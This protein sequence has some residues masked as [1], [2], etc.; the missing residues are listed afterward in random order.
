[1]PKA[2]H[3]PVDLIGCLFVLQA[4]PGT[5]LPG[6]GPGLPWLHPRRCTQVWR[7][8]SARYSS[9]CSSNTR[10]HQLHALP[11]YAVT[12]DLHN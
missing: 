5:G 12:D 1:M 6:A 9:S 4:R 11:V 3:H 10:S 2:A 8:H 7:A